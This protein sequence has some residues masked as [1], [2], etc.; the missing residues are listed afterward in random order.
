MEHI[1]FFVGDL[2]L[3]YR[4]GST[5]LYGNRQLNELAGSI[6]TNFADVNRVKTRYM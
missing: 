2:L 3:E 1:S 6:R 5:V 4:I